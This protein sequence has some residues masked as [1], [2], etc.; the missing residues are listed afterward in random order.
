M[1]TRAAAFSSKVRTLNDFYNNVTSGVPPSGY[2]IA[3]AVKYFSQTLL[4]V[5]KEMTIEPNQ[6][7]YSGKHSYRISKYPSLNY[8][9]LYHSLI[10]LI[11]IVPAI[12]L[13][14]TSLAQSILHALACLA[15]FLPYDLLDALPYTFVS[16]LSTFPQ[17]VHKEILD[18]LCQTL[19]PINMAYTEYPEHSMTTTS[20]ASIIFIVL[21]NIENQTSARSAA[22]NLLFFYWPMLIPLGVDR[23]SLHFKFNARK[24]VICQTERC[25]EKKNIASKVCVNA[26]LSMHGHDSPPPLYM[27]TDCYKSSS[28]EIQ[29]YCR[30]ILLPVAEID[31]YCQNKSCISENKSAYAICYSVECCQTNSNQAIS[32]CRQC[33]ERRH[34]DSNHVYQETIIDMWR[35]PPDVQNHLVEAIISLLKEADNLEERRIYDSVGEERKTLL[36]ETTEQMPTSNTIQNAVVCLTNDI[37]VGRKRLSR[38]GVYLCVGLIEPTSYGPPEIFGRL[39]SMLFQWFDSSTYLP[40]D[41]VGNRL[42]TLKSEHIIP[43]I[44]AVVKEHYELVVSILLPNPMDFAKVGGVWET[45]ANRTTQIKECLNKLYNLIPYDIITYEIWDYIMPYWMEAIR[46]EISESDLVDL[47]LFRKMFDTDMSPLSLTREQLYNFIIDRFQSP[48]PAG[49]QEQALQWLQLLCQLEIFIPVQLIVQIFITG[50][51]SLQKLESRAQRREVYTSSSN[52]QSLLNS[53]EQGLNT[54]QGNDTTQMIASSAKQFL[55]FDTY[56]TYRAHRHQLMLQQMTGQEMVSIIK[57]EEEEFII[58]ESELNSTCSIMMI[59]MLLKQMELQQTPQHQGMY[60]PLSKEI[61]SLLNK[62]LI[63]PWTRRHRC[64]NQSSQCTFCEEYILWFSIAND[65]LKHISPRDEIK[66][67]ELEVP[68]V[69]DLKQ[70]QQQQPPT[71][72]KFTVDSGGGGMGTTASVSSSNEDEQT[73]GQQ[74]LDTPAVVSSPPVQQPQV[75]VS[76]TPEL[77]VEN[78]PDGGVWITSHGVFYFKLN[79]LHIHLQF[80]YSVLKEL[81]KIIDIDALYYLL[82]CL[83]LLILNDECLET[84]AKDNRGFLTYCL[85]KL[86]VHHIWKI[87]SLGHDHLNECCVPLLL[88]ALSYES[89]KT[90]FS[91]YRYVMCAL[92]IQLDTVISDRSLIIHRLSKLYLILLQQNKQQSTTAKGVFS[93]EFFLNRFDTLS[94]ESQINL[95]ESGDIVSPQSIG[96]FNTE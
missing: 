34:I 36:L 8:S 26:I 93:W 46:L 52:E 41:E 62:Q 89:G 17:D 5:L 96:G 44:K 1:A 75:Q 65:L 14:Q 60:N 55:V 53:F 56:E 88:H 10:N 31:L 74:N 48:A 64:R 38:Y 37:D 29:Q 68:N 72:P 63:L 78:N 59:D 70:Q 54:M 80:F 91:A 27:C 71:K 33:H 83:K 77:K 61:L 94:L 19:L 51:N 69:N 50:I 58:N 86:L 92:E 76:L 45:M 35:L 90:A 95:E 30:N 28:K 42:G 21:E 87:L 47:Q 23:R 4:G 15:P 40:S 85:E 3:N 32:L 24:P 66:L 6:D 9:S 18:T 25:I 81:D 67:P 84:A 22:V 79:T 43:W 82:C 7:Q 13:G 49:V 20:I 2:D 12:S 57:E 39:L 11:D 16:A 73:N